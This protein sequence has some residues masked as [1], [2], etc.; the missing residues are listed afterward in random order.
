MHTQ[1]ALEY[2]GG[3]AADDKKR[4]LLAKAA[5]VTRQTVSQWVKLG[6]IPLKNASQLAAKSGG[7][8]PVELAA[9]ETK[10]KKPRKQ[11]AAVA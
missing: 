7:K 5:G 6:Y 8:C 4:G 3:E 11:R 10:V 9:Y 2:F 1:K